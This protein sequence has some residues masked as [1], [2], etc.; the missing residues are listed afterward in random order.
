M[1]DNVEQGRVEPRDLDGRHIRTMTEHRYTVHLRPPSFAGHSEISVCK[2]HPV[3]R[4]PIY[5]RVLSHSDQLRM[6]I[7]SKGTVYLQT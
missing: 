2:A 1:K 5:R 6:S 3:V 7:L 4:R